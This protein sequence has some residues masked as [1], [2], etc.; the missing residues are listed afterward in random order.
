MGVLVEDLFGNESRVVGEREDKEFYLGLACVG[1]TSVGLLM[2]FMIMGLDDTSFEL[3]S[4][5]LNHSQ[6]WRDCT[7]QSFTPWG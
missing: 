3:L 4:T 7:L 1:Q 2:S 5:H 6:P